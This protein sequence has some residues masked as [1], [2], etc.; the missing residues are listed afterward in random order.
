MEGAKESQGANRGPCP[1]G[2]GGCV[3]GHCPWVWFLRGAGALPHAPLCLAPSVPLREAFPI[4]ELMGMLR[5]PKPQQFP[6]QSLEQRGAPWPPV[7]CWRGLGKSL[8]S[9]WPW[10]LLWRPLPRDKPDDVRGGAGD[11]P[12]APLCF[13]LCR[14]EEVHSFL[15]ALNALPCEV[16]VRW[17]GG[18]GPADRLCPL[19][20]GKA[21]TRLQAAGS[22]RGEG[23]PMRH[24]AW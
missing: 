15:G 14:L 8:E 18:E 24:E 13:S 7:Q 20:G 12:Q 5:I 10:P 3:C 1:A 4:S 2:A 16:G 21:G 22:Q 23:S 9:F 11:A 17:H 6:R 19:A